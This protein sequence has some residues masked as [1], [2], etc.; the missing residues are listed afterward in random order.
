M[1]L[2][3]GTVIRSA[4]KTF[5]ARA[6]KVYVL[7]QAGPFKIK[8]RHIRAVTSPLAESSVPALELSA[9]QTRELVSAPCLKPKQKF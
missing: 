6:A 7:Y 1:V 4:A 8:M 5:V 3:G 9:S 2:A